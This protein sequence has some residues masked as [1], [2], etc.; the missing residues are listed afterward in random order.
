LI[1]FR[2]WGD[3]VWHNSG[4]PIVPGMPAGWQAN[5]LHLL[6]YTTDSLIV[7][8]LVTEP[9]GWTFLTGQTVSGIGGNNQLRLYAR[10]AVAGDTAPTLED[11]DTIG[12]THVAYIVGWSGVSK[13]AS[14]TDV[15]GAWQTNGNNGTTSNAPSITPTTGDRT[16]L[17][18]ASNKATG[19][20]MSVSGTPAA[21]E[22]ADSNNQDV[23]TGPSAS[24]HDFESTY[25]GATGTGQTATGTRTVTFSQGGARLSIQISLLPEQTNRTVAVTAVSALAISRAASF[26]RTLALGATGSV[27]VSRVAEFRRSLSLTAGSLLSIAAAKIVPV[28]IALTAVCWLTFQR[29]ATFPRTLGLQTG[30]ALTCQRA[31]TF[32]RTVAVTSVSIVSGAAKFVLG[33]LELRFTQTIARTLAFT[34]TIRK[35]LGFTQTVRGKQS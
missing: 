10:R 13:G 17:V 30:P 22:R 6:V 32:A 31:A 3:P 20:T 2:A 27:N 26:L 24:V 16:I 4:D 15:I 5:D 25:V 18:C 21:T 8:P 23:P 19:T 33:R 1:A 28:S 14:L 9:S 7:S 35:A 11:N 29:V 12:H 34:Q